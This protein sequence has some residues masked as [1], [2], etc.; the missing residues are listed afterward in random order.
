M[1]ILHKPDTK[2]CIQ[3]TVILRE[4]V[5][6]GGHFR[7][8][9]PVELQPMP[10]SMR[11]MFYPYEELP[12]TILSDEHGRNQMTF[13]L[14]DK[15]VGQEET[16]KAAEAVR[17]YMSSLY[18]QSEL[19]PVHLYRERGNCVGWFCMELEEEEEVYRHIKAVLSVCGRMLLVTATYP[20]GDAL[21]GETML[22]HFF[23][24]LYREE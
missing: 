21:K 2:G 15:A 10:E 9:I 12:D 14:L 22:R 1:G 4:I 13:Q 19:S 5:L 6:A 23:G 18:P 7:A 17:E 8:E 20:R 24:T 16:G 3:E 11:G